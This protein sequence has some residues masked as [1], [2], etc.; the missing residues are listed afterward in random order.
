MNSSSIK[1]FSKNLDQDMEVVVYG[2]RGKPVIVFPS[3]GGHARDYEGF[4][5]VHAVRQ[6]VESGR[7]RLF[8]VSSIDNQSWAN[9]DA[10]PEQRALRHEDY[11]RYI[12]AEVYPFISSEYRGQQVQCMT[13][14]CSMGGYHAANFFF[15]HPDIFDCV[16]SLS[17]L[18]QLRMFIGDYVDLNVYY[19]C[20]LYYLPNLTD[21]KYLDAYR[22]STI[23]VCVGQGAWEHEMIADAH[24]L[25]FVL[26]TKN[27]PH[28]IDF[29]GHD[30]YHD[31][32]W[33]QRQLPYFLSHCNLEGACR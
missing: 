20:P 30:V 7:V 13:T 3:Q 11:D 4:G 18:F 32:P 29:W 27:I 14:G 6:F 5:M 22:K 10:R 19:N 26:E 33:W 8:C 2:E 17:G 9:W 16:I 15:R 1:W 25:K 31:W 28:W 12:V 24:A 23:I 21:Q